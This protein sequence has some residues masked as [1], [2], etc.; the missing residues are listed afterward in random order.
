MGGGGL[1]SSFSST[2][3]VR[4]SGSMFSFQFSRNH[5]WERLNAFMICEQ[6][7]T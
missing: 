1:G 2:K 7:V 5:E 3:D 6:C 4:V